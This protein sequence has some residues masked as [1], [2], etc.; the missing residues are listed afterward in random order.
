MKLNNTVSG[1]SQLA[2][3]VVDSR[4]DCA[5]SVQARNDILP[6]PIA[7]LKC[8]FTSTETVGLLGTGAQDVHLDFRTAQLCLAGVLRAINCVRL[9]GSHW[10]GQTPS[11]GLRRHLP[12]VPESDARSVWDG[13]R[14]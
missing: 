11:T 9:R 4:A 6:K 14:W 13:P 7:W 5:N 1:G 8:C 12:K 2:D 3:S 10:D